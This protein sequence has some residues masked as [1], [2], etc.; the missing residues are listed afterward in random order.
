MYLFSGYA[1]QYYEM[2]TM[3]ASRS[4]HLIYLNVKGV[5]LFASKTRIRATAVRT[6]AGQGDIC[7][8]PSDAARLTEISARPPATVRIKATFGAARRGAAQGDFGSARHGSR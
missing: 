5:T 4:A 3:S 2:L 6:A 8:A 1:L 7:A